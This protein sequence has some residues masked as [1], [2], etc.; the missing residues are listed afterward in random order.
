[1]PKN[2]NTA[3]IAKNERHI[4]NITD[5]GSSGHGIGR[6]NGFTVF[7]DGGVPGDVLQTLI[8]KVKKNFAYA[9][10]VNIISPSPDRIEA[11]C[12]AAESCGGCQLQQL[13]YEAQLRLKTQSVQAHMERIGGFD[14][15]RVL[16]AIASPKPFRYRN[17]A[18]FPVGSDTD[19]NVKIGFYA[20]HSHRIIDVDSCLL[21]NSANDLIIQVFREYIAENNIKPYDENTHTGLIR[22]VV[23]RVGAKTGEVMI[24]IV[25]N[26][27]RL[28]NEDSLC[29][30]LR[31]IG[32]VSSIILNE[33]RDKTNVIMGAKNRIL[34]GKPSLSDYIGEIKFDISPNSFFQ[35]NPFQTET[36]YNLALNTADVSP[37]DNV[38]DLYCGIGTISLFF[39]RHVKSV[40]GVEIVPEA[41]ADAK[42]NAEQNNIK[43]VEFY[44]GRAEEIAPLLLEKAGKPDIVIVDPP[45]SGCDPSLL[46][47]L[48]KISPEKILYI[49]CDSATLARDMRILCDN[50]YAAGDVQPVDQFCQTVHVETVVLLSHKIPQKSRQLYQR[51]C[52]LWRG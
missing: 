28:P 27:S 45:R 15:L 41:I 49:S 3:P 36:L 50:G 39:A 33:N 51:G 12:P 44:S 20:R 37:E 43:N 52:G 6:I 42:R 22:H 24:C 16:P 1:M 40:T 30:M 9:K 25:A 11:P 29:Q 2:K 34:W 47:T 5:I 7:V 21:Q 32:G 10:L 4:V 35:V 19:G 13:S 18:Q 38:W 17:K 31:E 8:L 46:D 23:T 14:S 26:S 48:I